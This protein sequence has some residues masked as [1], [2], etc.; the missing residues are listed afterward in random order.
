M[1]ISAT[2]HR[3]N[4]L[5]QEY[6]Y[7]GPYSNYLKTK[8]E[9]IFTIYQP[10]KVISGMAQGFDTI[11]VLIALELK[12]PVLAAIPFKGQENYWT[13]E[14]KRLYRKILKNDLVNSYVVSYGGYTR[15]KMQIR[16]EYMVNKCNILLA[17]FNNTAGGTKNTINY[18]QKVGR[19]II[20]INP[21]DWKKQD[22]LKQLKLF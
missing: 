10:E 11:F 22:Q 7:K 14:A 1:I 17:C 21:E 9:E 8:V 6:N 2:G 13:K 19:K 12:I 16:N 4:K 3:P 18:A 20:F 5:G 15:D